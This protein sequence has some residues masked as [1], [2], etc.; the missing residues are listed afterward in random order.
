MKP[1]ASLRRAVIKDHDVITKA[2]TIMGNGVIIVPPH[3]FTH[4][5]RWY[6]QLL[7]LHWLQW[8]NVHNNF[9]ENP[10]SHSRVNTCLQTDITRD[11]FQQGR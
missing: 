3:D 6:Y 10:C 7:D 8:L 11:D 2:F 1:M 9:H 4:P 5:S